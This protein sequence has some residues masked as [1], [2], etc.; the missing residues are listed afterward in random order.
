[1][2]RSDEAKSIV[3]QVQEC[4]LEVLPEDETEIL[5][6]P[7]YSG[8]PEREALLARLR[9]AFDDEEGESE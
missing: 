4:G 5:F 9:E 3:W 8:S 1:M 7:V 2:A 6:N